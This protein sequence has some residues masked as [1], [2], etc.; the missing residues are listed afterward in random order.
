MHPFWKLRH[1]E[2]EAGWSVLLDGERVAELDYLH[3]DQPFHLFQARLLIDDAT[4][5]DYALRNTKRE[6]GD[7]L[8]FHCRSGN[9]VVAEREFFVKLSSDGHV[10]VRDMRP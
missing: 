1:Q 2:H 5:I 8:Q 9:T 4:K 3:D 7:K 10:S 6:P